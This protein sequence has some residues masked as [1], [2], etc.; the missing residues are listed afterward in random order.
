MPRRDSVA[1]VYVSELD[2]TPPPEQTDNDWANMLFIH[3]STYGSIKL[4]SDIVK[5]PNAGIEPPS[6]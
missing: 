3:I 1:T 2:A 6:P 5:Q 4:C